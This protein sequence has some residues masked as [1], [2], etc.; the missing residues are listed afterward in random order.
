MKM[1][2]LAGAIDMVIPDQA[3]GWRK[4]ASEVLNA[5]GI[6]TFDPSV[7]FGLCRTDNESWLS[8]S[9][10]VID[11][12]N[13]ALD[14]SEIVLVEMEFDCQHTGTTLE[15]KKAVDEGKL[16]VIWNSSKY[17]PMYLH[18]VPNAVI[19]PTLADCI[20][21]IVAKVS[22]NRI[23][24]EQ[25]KTLEYGSDKN[26]EK[27]LIQ[28]TDQHPLKVAQAKGELTDI[29]PR[30]VLY[31]K[32][33]DDTGFDIM[34]AEDVVIPAS[35]KM[36]IPTHIAIQPPKGYWYRLVGRSSTFH[37]HGMLV[38]E[39]IIDTQFRGHLYCNLQNL[40]DQEQHIKA[41]DS[42][43]QLIFHEIVGEDWDIEI[44]D[45]LEPSERGAN[46]FGSTTASREHISAV[47][48]KH[49]Q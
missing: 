22:G 42:I 34:C 25:R 1:C 32:Y 33:R 40:T 39:G 13:L 4:K 15:M 41:G 28:L 27:I 8:K 17:T 26:K 12:N 31:K 11:V 24:E 2:Y 6:H 19:L 7:A 23:S 45:A 3:K 30:M 29:D 14:N 43:A 44:V 35:G 47:Y 46:G 20:D 36:M 10:V 9:R 38:V 48:Q 18:A 16:V 37:V 21:Y 5:N 49:T